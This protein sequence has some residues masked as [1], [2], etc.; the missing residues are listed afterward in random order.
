[1]GTVT[2]IRRGKHYPKDF[3]HYWILA[4]GEQVD[5][6]V[7]PCG[8]VKKGSVAFMVELTGEQEESYIRAYCELRH[9]HPEGLSIVK[10]NTQF[11]YK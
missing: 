8:K 7:F 2:D 1:M 3:I 11:N 9:T 10:A 4:D 6:V 5:S